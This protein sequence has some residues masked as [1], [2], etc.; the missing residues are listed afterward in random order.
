MTIPAPVSPQ[1]CSPE[2]FRTFYRLN[3]RMALRLDQTLYLCVL[4]ASTPAAAQAL[5]RH[6]ALHWYRG[7]LYCE[8]EPGLYYAQV[9]AAREDGVRVLLEDAADCVPGVYTQYSPVSKGE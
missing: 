1:K 7:E 6:I 3:A 2:F 9:Y 4:R 8:M 5:E